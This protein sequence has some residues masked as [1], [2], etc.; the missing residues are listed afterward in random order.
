MGHLLKLKMRIFKG[1]YAHFNFNKCSIYTHDGASSKF[2]I[3]SRETDYSVVY[4]ST[5]LYVLN[6]YFDLEFSKEIKVF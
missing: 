1:E 3:N 6:L 2:S 5:A 4:S